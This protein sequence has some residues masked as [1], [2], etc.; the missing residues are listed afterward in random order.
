METP[1]P[2]SK[3]IDR[4]VTP[5]AAAEEGP[6]D[7]EFEQPNDLPPRT[8]RHDMST[9]GAV[10]LSPSDLSPPVKNS[11]LDPMVNV[12]LS[13][14]I[15]QHPELPIEQSI[16][17]LKSMRDPTGILE[18]TESD[19]IQQYRHDIDPTEIELSDV[20]LQ[21]LV[22][23]YKL[24]KYIASFHEIGAKLPF[25]TKLIEHS[26]REGVP[27]SE[28]IRLKDSVLNQTGEA[29]KI[30]QRKLTNWGTR[31]TEDSSV[32]TGFAFEIPSI[33]K[34]VRECL[35][36]I[37][38]CKEGDTISFPFCIST[39]ANRAVA[40]KLFT[41]DP[42]QIVLEIILPTGSPFPFITMDGIEA[43]V[44]LPFGCQLQFVE[45]KIK[46]NR[47]IFVFRYVGVIDQGEFESFID[48]NI[49]EIKYLYRFRES[50]RG[51]KKTKKI[52]RTK[53]NKRIKK[54]RKL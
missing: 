46:D 26:I 40:T 35:T 39:S 7:I 19:I 27:R 41:S 49:A 18:W 20:N 34:Y 1:P 16:A 10:E 14:F 48:R 9:L 51:G 28:V 25:L 11:S 6:A 29:C 37:K 33:P 45:K 54:S 43:E 22:G 42:G 23:G 38:N 31:T 5:I 13:M 2:A 12:K 15:K 53:K 36:D 21:Y 3:K 52:K 24:E 32:F 4:K 44:L 17:E 8:P 30:I 47:Q 50:T